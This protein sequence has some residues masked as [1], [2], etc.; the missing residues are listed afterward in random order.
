MQLPATLGDQVK[1]GFLLNC[2]VLVE[3]ESAAMLGLAGGTH[4]NVRAGA[5]GSGRTGSVLRVLVRVH[6][7]GLHRVRVPA[8]Y[9]TSAEG[10]ILPFLS[11]RRINN[12]RVIS[13]P[14]GFE[15]RP[16]HHLAALLRRVPENLHL[17]AAADGCLGSF[18]DLTGHLIAQV[19]FAAVL[20][21]IRGNALQ[22]DGCRAALGAARWP[23]RDA[24][25]RAC[26]GRTSFCPPGLAVR[27][28]LRRSFPGDVE[29]PHPPA[30][31]IAQQFFGWSVSHAHT[32]S[33]LSISGSL[34]TH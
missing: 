13:G 6:S 12:L 14:S 16:A 9:L 34:Y 17:G 30:A 15:S 27:R 32:T 19:V 10:P 8:V 3:S 11:I 4:T 26:T 7:I 31:E 29:H 23:H 2:G 33:A 18:Q 21:H 20:T 5:F 24:S 25:L 1:Q 22:D 28:Q